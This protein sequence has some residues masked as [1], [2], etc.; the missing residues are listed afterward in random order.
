MRSST[1][2]G[3]DHIVY[4][5][6]CIYNTASPLDYDTVISSLLSHT[7]DS[8]FLENFTVSISPTMDDTA[9]VCGSDILNITVS[10][11]SRV[12]SL[13]MHT[14]KYNIIHR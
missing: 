6:I 12:Y 1:S 11:V 3:R 2:P 8:V 5:I 10:S 13:N 4:N 14:E 7:A 9:T